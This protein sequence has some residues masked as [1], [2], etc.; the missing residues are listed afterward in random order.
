MQ[1]TLFMPSWYDKVPM[2]FYDLFAERCRGPGG[3]ERRSK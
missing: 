2:N 1:R 3:A